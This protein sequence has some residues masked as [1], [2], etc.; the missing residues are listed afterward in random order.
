M[1]DSRDRKSHY[2][3]ADWPARNFNPSE[4][5]V[6]AEPLVDPKDVLLKSLHI[7][8]GLIKNFV[9]SMN[10]E[11]QAFKGKKRKLGKPLRDDNYT[12][13]MT[14]LLQKYHQLGCNMSLKIHFLHSHLD[15]FPPSCGAFSDEHGE[16]FHQDIY[17]ME[18]RY[19]GR[20][21]ET[22]L[23]DYC[24]SLRRRASELTRGK[25]KDDDLMKPHM[26]LFRSNHL[27]D[28]VACMGE[29]R[30]A[31]RVLVVRE[32]GKR[33]LGMPRRRWEDNIKM[34]LREVGNDDKDWINLAQDRNRWRA[35]VRATMNLGKRMENMEDMVTGGEGNVGFRKRKRNE[36]NKGRR[37]KARYSDPFAFLAVNREIEQ[38]PFFFSDSDSPVSLL[39]KRCSHLQRPPAATNAS[40]LIS[41]L[42]IRDIHNLLARSGLNFREDLD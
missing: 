1:W 37:K 14:V 8:L 7:K 17:V 31:Y 19:Q 41:A 21:N 33:P 18:Q 42:R 35:Y 9:K 40:R 11:G 3:Q 38:E 24:W 15:F 20:W 12:Q 39:K 29:S 2:I 27:P 10:Q 30:N 13:L 36:T 25:I 34:D 22:M 26:I 28:H 23:G 16:R 4:K 6:V 32:E 5:N